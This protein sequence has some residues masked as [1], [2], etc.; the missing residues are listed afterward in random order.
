[1]NCWFS[2]YLFARGCDRFLATPILEL[3]RPIAHSLPCR[4]V[5]RHGIFSRQLAGGFTLIEL[6]VVIAI[7]A[8][9]AALLLPALAAAKR[10]AQAGY[11]LN[12]TKQLNLAWIMYSGDNNERLVANNGWVETGEG[13]NWG[14]NECNT[15]VSLLTTN[16]SLFSPYIKTYGT[17][18]CPG[19]SLASQNGVRVRTYS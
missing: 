15:N 3:M 2:Y 17:Y 6:L 8:I 19:D 1:M 12:N 18:H 14:N 11:C 4:R 5:G 13:M 7:I 10:K 16:S 9:L